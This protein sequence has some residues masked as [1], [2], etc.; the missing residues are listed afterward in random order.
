MKYAKWP[1]HH[2]CD[3]NTAISP[4]S[5]S[6]TKPPWLAKISNALSKVLHRFSSDRFDF[7]LSLSL[8]GSLWN[9][10]DP[11]SRSE[12]DSYPWIIGITSRKKWK[13]N[14]WIARNENKGRPVRSGEEWNT[15]TTREIRSWTRTDRR[16]MAKRGRLVKRSYIHH[17]GISLQADNLMNLVSKL[18]DENR[19]LRDDVER[20]S[21]LYN[22]SDL[23]SPTETISRSSLLSSL[24]WETSSFSLGITREELQCIKNL[25][26]ENIKLKRLLKARE[27]ELTQKSLDHEAVSQETFVCI[28]R[29]AMASLHQRRRVLIELAEL[30][31]VI[32]GSIST[33]TCLQNQLF[34]AAKEHLFH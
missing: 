2:P 10:D 33:G 14:R 26:E 17:T 25:T 5:T 29:L 12:S 3:S 19:R 24:P 32:S 8:F 1:A 27:K 18:E 22:K 20:N 34:S 30:A 21:E 23:P 15:W 4:F 11:W 16:T 28:R 31:H 9:G 13:R 6:T 7:S